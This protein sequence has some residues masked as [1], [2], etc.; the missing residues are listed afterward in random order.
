MIFCQLF[1]A[2]FGAL[3]SRATLRS[4]SFVDL[5]S[6]LGIIQF[7]NEYS[8]STEDE[9][10]LQFSNRFQIYLLD[11]MLYT[12][13]ILAVVLTINDHPPS[14]V[15]FSYGMAKA[16]TG[17]ISFQ[18]IGQAGNFARLMANNAVASIFLMDDKVWRLF[19]LFTFSAITGPILAAIFYW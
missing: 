13:V 8:P 5:F 3:L 17:Y 16:V 19:Y 4:S 14:S 2:F 1:G 12:F 6:S 18:A 7:P 9:E 11:S 10:F 15:G